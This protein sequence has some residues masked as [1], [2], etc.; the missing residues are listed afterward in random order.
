VAVPAAALVVVRVVELMVS[1]GLAG[2]ATVVPLVKNVVP[3]WCMEEK[4]I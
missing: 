2:V 3:G 1:F 4:L